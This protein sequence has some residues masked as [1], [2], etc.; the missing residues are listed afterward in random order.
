MRIT[1]EVI[2][3]KRTTTT[4]KIEILEEIKRNNTRE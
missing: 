1:A 3:L 4:N 2:I